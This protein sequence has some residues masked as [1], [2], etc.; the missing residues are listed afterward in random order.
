MSDNYDDY[1]RE[2]LLKL[3]R[4]KDRRQT[5]L[6]DIDVDKIYAQS[7]KQEITERLQKIAENIP[8]VVYQFRLNLDGSSC[9]PYASAAI[10]D[11]YH[12]TPEEVK[13]S[14][15]K[16]FAILHPDDY[17]KIVISITESAKNL[18]PWSQE[19]RT[20]FEDGSGCWLLGNALPQLEADGSILWNGFITDIT[21][22]K[23][24]EFEIA[25]AKN[26]LQATLDAIP[27][28]M[29]EVG[30]DG[31]YYDIHTPHT[32][33][34]FLPIKEL[35]GKKIPDVLP[36]DAANIIMETLHEALEKSY[37]HGKQFKLQ[38]DQGEMWFELSV[39]K[40]SNLDDEQP[41]F[42]ALSR[43]VTK[44][45]HFELLVQ[46][47]E[48]RFRTVADAAPVLIWLANTDKLCIWFNKK[49]LDFT[50][51]TL[52]QEYGNGWADGVH[53]DDL[54]RCLDTYI[55]SFDNRQ[56][57]SME[58]R[59]KNSQGEY[60]WLLD[61]GVPVFN[62]IGEFEGYIGSCTD[63]H[64]HKQ[65]AQE[66]EYSEFRWK[67]AIE[68][69]GDGLWDWDI[70]TSEVF[71]S[72]KWK[73]MLGFAENEIEDILEEWEKR[74]HPDD[75][76][77]VMSEI[78]DYLEGRSENY[79][80]EHRVLC[81]DGSYKWILDRGIIVNRG[82]NG[83][84]LR[85]IGTHTDITERKN[86][87]HL[88]LEAKAAAESLAKSKS[89]FLA[90]M[91]HE[92]RTPMT[93]IIGLSQL[94]LNKEMPNDVRDSLTKIHQSAE[95]LLGILNDILDLSK[96]DAGKLILENSPFNL[97]IL[98]RNLHNFFFD[99]AKS[100]N[101]EFSISVE[102]GFPN[103]LIGDSLRIQQILSNLLGNA[104][105]FTQ[106]GKIELCIKQIENRADETVLR[107][108]VED[109]G[110]GI[111]KEH[112]EN[113][114]KP[115]HQADNSITRRFGGTGLGLTISHDLLSLMGS[116]FHIDSVEGKG[117][118]IY[119]DLLLKVPN[120]NIQISKQN[121]YLSSN[122]QGKLQEK[123]FELS[124]SLAGIRILLAEDN[125]LNQEIVSGFL[126]LSGI[127]VDI[128][129]N[130]VI[131]LELLKSNSYQAILMDVNMPEMDGLQATKLIREQP[132][133]A[134]LP[135]IALTAGITVEEQEK[136]LLAGM[137]NLVEKP[138]NPEVLLQ[139]LSRCIK[140]FHCR[141]FS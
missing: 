24:K 25:T 84:P 5:N 114:F 87:E 11:I 8:G 34:L 45:K 15:E 62:S 29:F 4:E 91:S 106:H 70:E 48:K 14:A 41:R 22:R 50:G 101:L 118:T 52:D 10:K 2:E 117:T 126:K 109:T 100:K 92:I 90:N 23:Q 59:L 18:T 132:K 89:E 67:F 7:I 108:S 125:F 35:I 27:D 95:S 13:E 130:G 74:V 65:L 82:E 39:T 88:I 28:L 42:I 49:W 21:D 63:I 135:I 119:F 99:A 20:H 140:F 61:N 40:T 115:F 31:Y 107:F 12:V 120:T 96:L 121:S 16:V 127:E 103:E 43:N 86:T 72:K 57:F 6:A 139:T 76:S 98:F 44:R 54:Q 137:N 36:N 58:Y 112:Q 110:I 123:L 124:K 136:C 66:L 93:A 81:K 141:T 128:A 9:F 51:R 46:E 38:L 78:K 138:I 19:Y 30:L 94:A 131:V 97:V 111:K 69:S 68:G 56:P 53:P 26:K 71:F 102:H 79:A 64:E 134:E 3:L 37:S 17:E 104:I 77:Q 116:D 113:L 105:K 60:R 129:E 55:T 133:Y 47:S 75:V 85:L 80:N 33:L 83:K 122:Q 73:S 1:S 32:E